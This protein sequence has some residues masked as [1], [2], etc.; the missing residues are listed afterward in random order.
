[1]KTFRKAAIPLFLIISLLASPVLNQPPQLYSLFSI[2]PQSSPY[3]PAFLLDNETKYVIILGDASWINSVLPLAEWKTL[4]GIPAEI[5]TVESIYQN[6][7]GEDNASKI[8]NFLKDLYVSKK[9]QWALLV[10]DVDKIPIRFF[11]MG[12]TL[13]PSDY[14]YAALD[15]SFDE[16]HDGH[17]GELGEIDWTPELYVGRIPV[18]SIDELES[19]VNKTLTYEQYLYLYSGEWTGNVLLA[20]GEISSSQDI[21]GWRAK[22][23][24]VKAFPQ[25]SDYT[26]LTYDS[27]RE[28]K[29]LTEQSFISKINEGAAI[30]DIC[31]HGRETALYISQI[32]SPF[33]NSTTA[34]ALS[35]GYRLPLFFISAC[36][37]GCIDSNTDSVAESLL[38]NPGGGAIAVIASTRTTFGGDT[39]NDAADTFFDYTFFRIFFSAD[40]PFTHRPGYALYEAKKEYYKSYKNLLESNTTYTQLFIEYILLGD[41]ELPVCFGPLK[42]LNVNIDGRLVPGK[43]ITLKVSDGN[44]PVNG[45]YVCIQGWNYYHTYLTD[46]NGEVHLPCPERGIYN[47]TVTKEVFSPAQISIEVG[48]PI[49]ILIDEYHQQDY[50]LEFW[51]NTSILRTTLNACLFHFEILETQITLG[52]LKNFNVLIVYYPSQNY[53]EDELEAIRNFIQSGGSLLIIGENDPA[54]ASNANK[55]A[56]YF[57]I[58][59]STSSLSGTVTAKCIKAPQTFRTNEVLLKD[60][61]KVEGGTPILITSYDAQEFIIASCIKWYNGR[62]AFVSDL[63][64]WKNTSIREKDNFQLFKSLCEWLAGDLAPAQFNISAPSEARKGETVSINITADHPYNIINLTIIVVSSQRIITNTSQK[65]IVHLQLDTTELG[66]NILVY[67]VAVTEN[68]EIYVSDA[69]SITVIEDRIP[70]NLPLTVSQQATWQIPIMVTITATM[71]IILLLSHH[72]TQKRSHTKNES[73]RQKQ[74]IS[75]PQ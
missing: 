63:D 9:L 55:L 18:S 74:R 44:S 5:Y 66:G 26:L 28:F 13:V 36:L 23:A 20:G 19:F 37:A 57:N 40:Q 54:L 49:K 52:T 43:E 8:R 65:S 2:H 70:L 59:F 47:V 69:K 24:T 4:K 56:S 32:G 12:S 53:T 38:K 27:I 67:A 29:N 11:T 58:A 60:P 25:L 72:I 71:T 33:L 68:G 10:G 51:N 31:S 15:G 22:Q 14:Y 50:H 73:R 3:T 7:T 61:G 41:P 45:A 42:S 21:Q 6:Y 39:L 75:T 1:M 34:E 30:V 16:D 48:T 46:K 35:N 17:Y 62:V 64:L